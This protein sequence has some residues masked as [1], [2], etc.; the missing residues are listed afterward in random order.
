[1][2]SIP[3]AVVFVCWITILAGCDRPPTDSALDDVRAAG[4]LVVL[5]RNAPTTYYLDRDRYAGPE[6]DMM[7]AFAASLGVKPRFV[8]YESLEGL[9]NAIA[10]GKGDIAAAGLTRTTRR[11]EKLL[12][13]PTYQRI[14]Q[15]VVCRRGGKQPSGPAEFTDVDLTVVA[16]SSY[17]ARLKH[18]QREYPE[19][20]WQTSQDD[21]ETLLEK[22]WKREID[23]TVAD[24]N[25]AA[26]N[27][28][29]HPELV[30]TFALT[31]SEPLVWY[32]APGAHSLNEA[33]TKWFRQYR[34]N[35]Q[36][37]RTLDRYY[38]FVQRFD[39][40]DLRRF[41]RRVKSRLPKYRSWFKEAETQF[42]IR[43]TLLAA[44]AYQESHWRARAKSP[45]GVRGIMML[46]QPT[47]RE[48]GV[49]N[50]LDARQSIFGGARYLSRLRERL[51]EQIAEP[52]RT[53]L[54]L[55][56]YNVG[57]SHLRDAMK[58]AQQL[59]K[60]PMLWNDMKT[61]LPLL[62]E[63]RYYRNLDYG[64][65]RGEEPVLYVNR[66]RNFEDLIV[67]RQTAARRD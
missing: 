42:G 12:A 62:S 6:H 39:Y 65:A 24:S 48:L 67:R 57:W 33:L 58:L 64:Y 31:T 35:G 32:M 1:M 17:V 9:L 43:W 66:I 21:T 45:T 18:L 20:H 10:A 60:N 25:I 29:Y 53:W 8:V 47:A 11:V 14:R 51:P 61:V 34:S 23:C 50:R 59:E 26:V 56:A 28:R 63:K 55:A 19:L 44:Q 22:V 49:T 5:T 41:L 4:E 37:A 30:V 2:R 16:H 52:D 38:G 15:Q 40:V 7:Q 13:G 27:R 54:A 3:I 36:L 46:T